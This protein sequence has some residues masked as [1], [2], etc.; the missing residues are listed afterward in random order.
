M[1][2]IISIISDGAE[3]MKCLAKLL[4]ILQQLCIA[5]GIHLA[6]LDV[7]TK[8]V[9]EQLDDEEEESDGNDSESDFDNES[10]PDSENEESEDEAEDGPEID[11]VDDDNVPEFV[12]SINDLIIRLR[13]AVKK[14]IKSPIKV[15]KLQEAVKKWQKAND[16]EIKELV[17]I[18]LV[19]TNH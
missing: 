10:S 19:F 1:D 13:K 17:S 9:E 12:E 5:H 14:I 16:K 11:F 18:V 15:W 2:L 7:F 8:E 4:G 6:V 3:V